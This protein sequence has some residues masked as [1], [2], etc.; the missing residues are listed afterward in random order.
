MKN[1]REARIRAGLSQ[2]ELAEKVG[3]AQKTISN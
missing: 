2:V 1:I 3:V